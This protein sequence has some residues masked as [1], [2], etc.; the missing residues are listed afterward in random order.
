[1]NYGPY[2]RRIL[3]HLLNHII[4]PYKTSLLRSID[5]LCTLANNGNMFLNMGTIRGNRATFLLFLW[6]Y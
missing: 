2:N 6:H 5:V 1:M 3:F 4:G